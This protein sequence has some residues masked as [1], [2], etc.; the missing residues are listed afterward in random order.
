MNIIIKYTYYLVLYNNNFVL[1]T[2]SVLFGYAID[3]D[4]IMI[5]ISVRKYLIHT[6]YITVCRHDQATVLRRLT[7]RMR[8]E[9]LSTPNYFR[10]S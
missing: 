9:M 10:S 7:L 1:A 4:T 5:K 8:S 3:V 2:Q 6:E